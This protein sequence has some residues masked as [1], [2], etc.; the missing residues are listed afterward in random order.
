MQ[1]EGRVALVTGGS[2]GIG[3]MACL[4]FAREGAAVAVHYHRQ[5]E[6]AEAIAAQ[7]QAD[8]G[9]A[10]VV[11]ADVTE[12]EQVARMMTRVEGFAGVGGLHVLFANAGV[13]P[14]G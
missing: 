10:V 6:R 5:R 4:T 14:E 13:Y 1:L 8:G 2:G 12:P 11:Q 3:R 7:I 9:H